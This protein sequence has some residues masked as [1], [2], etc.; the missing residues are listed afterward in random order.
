MPSPNA[1]AFQSAPEAQAF[2]FFGPAIP[3]PTGVEWKIANPPS[4]AAPQLCARHSGANAATQT[5]NRK[6][7]NIMKTKTKIRAGKLACNHNQAVVGLKVA[8]RV[9]AGKITV[10]RNHAVTLG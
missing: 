9:K 7:G 10:N 8:T 1:A 3:L 4:Y 6:G 5:L 2:G